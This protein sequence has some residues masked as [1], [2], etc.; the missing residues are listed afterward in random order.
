LKKIF[1]RGF[2][3]IELLVVIA[4]IAI[5]AA[6]LFPVFARARE[7]ARRASCQSNLKQI[8][9]GVFMYNQD[10]DEKLP[11]AVVSSTTPYSTSNP[12][13]W[14]DAMQPYLKSTQIFQC[15][16][17]TGAPSS[18]P[19]SGYYSDYWINARA[20][21]L[22]DASFDA[23]AITTLLGDGTSGGVPAS[24]NGWHGTA[25]SEDDGGVACPSTYSASASVSPVLDR[26]L[27][28]S[29]FA[30]ADGHVKWLSTNSSAVSGCAGTDR[31]IIT[32]VPGG[33]DQLS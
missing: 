26:H 5:L 12:Y 27:D 8:A 16:S 31:G 30:F 25:R 18:D 28:G 3:L 4:I 29:N 19:T 33:S 7:N 10:Y 24:T 20:A 13:G 21:G 1:K 23:P 17:E 22:A 11:Q 32:F 15:P 6:I 14:V 9:L 2:T